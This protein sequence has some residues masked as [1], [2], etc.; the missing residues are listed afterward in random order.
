MSL[1]QPQTRSFLLNLIHRYC[2]NR[3][4]DGTPYEL[5]YRQD[6]SPYG[7]FNNVYATENQLVEGNIY[8]RQ[9]ALLIT[10]VPA[11]KPVKYIQWWWTLFTRN[12]SCV[13]PIINWTYE[14]KNGHRADNAVMHRFLKNSCGENIHGDVYFHSSF[15]AKIIRQI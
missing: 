9:K 7:C 13:L 1:I 6:R 2:H 10:E 3:P 15:L 11:F 12:I 14:K 8:P 4:Y 5:H